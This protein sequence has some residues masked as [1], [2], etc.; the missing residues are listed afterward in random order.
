MGKKPRYVRYIYLMPVTLDAALDDNY[1]WPHDCIQRALDH[2]VARKH[3]ELYDLTKIPDQ[4]DKATLL[5]T[6]MSIFQLIPRSAVLE[7]PNEHLIYL[8][9]QVFGKAQRRYVRKY[10][11][12]IAKSSGN[13]CGALL[14]SRDIHLRTCKMNDVHH[15][16]HE[17]VQRWFQDLAKQA[18]IQTGPAPPIT[19][20][21]VR[22]PTKQLGADL[23]LI[24]VSLRGEGRDG[25]CGVS[26]FS[27]VT[28]AAESY[29]EQ[30]ARVSLH[31]QQGCAKKIR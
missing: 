7:I 31:M 28:P 9:K 5:S 15:Q 29:C 30:A 8:A 13:I 21:S 16:K 14:D 11:P 24:D 18:H 10:C 20:P 22:N 1:V 17:T 3:D 6:D 19:Q 26:D 2:I 27:M 23:M 12:N 4:Q 25:K